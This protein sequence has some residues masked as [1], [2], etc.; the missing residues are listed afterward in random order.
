MNLKSCK[1]IQPKT[2]SNTSS[3]NRKTIFFFKENSLWFL[4]MRDY[5]MGKCNTKAIQ[6]DLGTFRILCYPDIFKTVVYPEP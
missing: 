2:K 4:Q 5:K 6:T 1:T 3:D